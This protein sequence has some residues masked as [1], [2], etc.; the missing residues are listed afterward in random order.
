VSSLHNVLAWAATHSR[1]PG[2]VERYLVNGAG[3]WVRTV[4][5]KQTV[6]VI[7]TFDRAY[8]KLAALRAKGWAPHPRS[9]PTKSASGH[10]S[11]CAH[12]CTGCYPRPRG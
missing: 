5:D 8:R 6:E 3:F 2:L 4:E 11:S 12:P 1:D 9:P 10:C 7:L